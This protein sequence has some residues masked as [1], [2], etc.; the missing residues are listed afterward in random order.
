MIKITHVIKQGRSIY[1]TTVSTKS[2]K[3]IKVVPREEEKNTL[4]EYFGGFN[5]YV[6]CD[7]T[8]ESIKMAINAIESNSFNGIENAPLEYFSPQNIVEK[9][10]TLR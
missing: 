4:K 3:V 6:F 7:N 2:G 5:R 1:M 8:V 10:L 9:I